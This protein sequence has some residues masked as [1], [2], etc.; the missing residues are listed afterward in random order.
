M[1]HQ[2]LDRFSTHLGFKLIAKFLKRL[3]VLLIIEQLAPLK[4]GQTWIDDDET[5]EVK[6]SLDISQGHIEKQ[7]N[8]GWKRL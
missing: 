7:A 5:L 3:V 4:G 6:N 8:A 1:G 2:I